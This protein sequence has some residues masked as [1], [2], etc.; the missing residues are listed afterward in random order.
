[1]QRAIFTSN[2]LNEILRHANYRPCSQ[3]SEAPIRARVR[4]FFAER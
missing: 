3:L 2:A 1:M 4:A